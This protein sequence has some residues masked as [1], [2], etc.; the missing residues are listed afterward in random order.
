MVVE[1]E[2]LHDLTAQVRKLTVRTFISRWE[3]L[4]VVA[5]QWL[6]GVLELRRG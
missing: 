1:R 2:D 4:Y 6:L 5:L 3:E